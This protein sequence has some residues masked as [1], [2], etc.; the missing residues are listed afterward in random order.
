MNSFLVFSVSCLYLFLSPLSSA[1]SLLSYSD[2]SLR[3]RSEKSRV[4]RL[5]SCSSCS[6]STWGGGAGEG[7]GRGAEEWRSLCA[8]ILKERSFSWVS[9]LVA[10]WAVAT[11]SLASSSLATWD[12]MLLADPNL[13]D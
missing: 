4:V 7:S 11:F 5:R 13:R 9:S 10:S 3:S 1:C 6:S 8:C 12:H 2:F